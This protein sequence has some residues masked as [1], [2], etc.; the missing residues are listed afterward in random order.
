MSPIGKALS[1]SLLSISLAACFQTELGG[2]VAGS[3]VRIT[4]LRTGD[5]IENGLNSLDRE[6]FIAAKSED[7]YDKLDD[8]GKMINL[9]NFFTDGSR[10]QNDTW[11]L[12]T[13]NGGADMDVDSDGALEEPFVP[14]AGKWRA[15]MTGRQL[16]DGGYVVSP[17]T[18]ALY[19]V[20][21]DELDVIDDSQL[22]SRLNELTREIL[23]D[24]NENG[25]V[26]YTDA[27]DWSVLV[28]KDLYLRDYTQVEALAQ[29]I[30]D[31]ENQGTVRSLSQAMFAEPVPDAFEFYQENISGPIV[32][33]FCVRCHAPGGVA[34]NNGA[35]LVLVMNNT[36]NFQATNH[37]N[38]QN[39]GKQ[40]PASRDLSTWVVSKATRQVRHGGGRV[41]EINSQEAMDLET[42]LNLIE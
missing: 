20:V 18:E 8:L 29:A 32:Q 13:A 19:Q 38:F 1:I 17:L 40:L 5:P 34:P 6:T 39:F 21:R 2:A 41:L 36:A 15:I 26:N 27:L 31:N 16:K 14:V 9:G 37:Q 7:A 42:Y 3:S 22:R 35:E 33:A 10:Y 12:V 23:P 28:H 4:E 24:V 25:T 30:R 11:Y